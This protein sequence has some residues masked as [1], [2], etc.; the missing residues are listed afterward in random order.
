M[1]VLKD[2]NFLSPHDLEMFIGVAE[3]V[4]IHDTIC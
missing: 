4:A 1:L 3:T 2:F